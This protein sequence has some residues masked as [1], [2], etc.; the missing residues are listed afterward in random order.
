MPPKDRFGAV[1]CPTCGELDRPP[2]R[3]GRSRTVCLDCGLIFELSS[4]DRGRTILCPGCN[5]F[6]GCL[7]PIERERFKPFWSLR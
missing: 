4:R 3:R 2:R 7:L 5:Y 1:A 6:L